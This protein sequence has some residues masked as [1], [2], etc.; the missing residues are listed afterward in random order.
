M[1][2]KKSK[3]NK[4][5]DGFDISLHIIN[6]NRVD[7]VK[8]MREISILEMIVPSRAA[9][10]REIYI[11]LCLFVSFWHQKE[12]EIIYCLGVDFF[13]RPYL[14]LKFEH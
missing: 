12:K 2:N 6:S 5:A 4:G 11:W 10:K 13:S 3:F 14:C 7:G 8:Q 1:R 9:P